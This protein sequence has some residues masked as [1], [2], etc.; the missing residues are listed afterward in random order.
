MSGQGFEQLALFPADSPASRLVWPGSEEA[1]TMTATSGRKCAASLQRYGQDGLSGKTY[2][3]LFEMHLTKYL[4]VSKRST[5][6]HGHML[7]RLNRAEPCLKGRESLL[8]PRPTTGA[9]LCGGTHNF[10]QMERL[11]DAGVITEEERRNLTQGNGGRSNP[12]LM[13]WLM[14]FPIGWTDLD[15]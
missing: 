13:E 11:R 3:D 5:T 6:A 12:D 9:P 7:S 10:K 1:R 4:I 15:A 8:W 14:G 2:L